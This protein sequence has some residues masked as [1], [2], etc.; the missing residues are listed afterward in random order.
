MTFYQTLSRYYDEIFALAPGEMSFLKQRLAGCAR[1]LDVGCGT[2]NK[3]ELLAAPGREIW[4]LDL[5]P[6]MIA[7]AQANHQAP[8]LNYQVGDMTAIGLKYPA[9]HFDAL[10]CLGN[11]LVHLTGDYELE[12]FMAGAGRILRPG[13]WWALQILNYDFIIKSR[14]T[15]LPLIETPR[16]VFRRLYDWRDDG[17]YFRAV[18]K[19]KSGPAYENEIPLRPILKNE[20]L[21][22]LADDFSEVELFGGYDGSPHRS[23]SLVTLAL[24]RRNG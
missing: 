19:I 23:D 8:G 20:L 4:G 3:T 10:V 12:A 15:E 1:I 22:L 24:A 2:G 17:L 16:T 13:G 7:L 14:L 21:E 6:D 9:G 11:T 18:L 5:D